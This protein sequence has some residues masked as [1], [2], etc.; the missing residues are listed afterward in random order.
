MN[1]GLFAT[2]QHVRQQPNIGAQQDIMAHQQMAPAAVRDAR[3][4]AARTARQPVQAQRPQLHAIS[5]QAPHS[6][7]VPAAAHTQATVIIN[8]PAGGRVGFSS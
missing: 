6:V 5:R 7:T 3:H 4:P 8:H 2:Q 1:S